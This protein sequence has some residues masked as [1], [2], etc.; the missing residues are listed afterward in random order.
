MIVLDALEK[1]IEFVPIG[2]RFAMS[3]LVTLIDLLTTRPP[4]GRLLV[5]ATTSRPDILAELGAGDCFDQR[6][7]VT[8]LRST[9]EAR[10][11]LEYASRESFTLGGPLVRSSDAPDILRAL[12]SIEF[13]IPIKRFLQMLGHASMASDDPVQGFLNQL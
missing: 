11:V 2:P 10:V 6:L 1:L 7:H 5:I 12:S 9:E 8:P 4:S 3:I 13:S